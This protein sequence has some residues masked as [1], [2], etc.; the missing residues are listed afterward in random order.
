MKYETLECTKKDGTLTVML[1]RPEV[2]NA[3]NESLMRELTTCFKDASL[4]STVAAVVLTGNGKSFCAGADLTWM[5]QMV[6]YSKEENRNDSRLLL[7]MYET[8]HACPK[9]VIGRVNGS[10]FGGGIGLV[11]ICDITIT[12]PESLFGFT[13]V[14]LGIIPAVISTFVAHRM[15]LAS[16]RR[17]FITGERFT[18]AVA[19]EVGLIDLVV[20]AERLDASVD[21]SLEQIYSS[22]PG[23]IKEVKHLL[24]KHL[25]LDHH[26]YKEYTVEKIAELRVS[27]EGQEG[28]SA[29]LEKR[30]PR[31]K[32]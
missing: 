5:K 16:M 28:I 30:K 13:E 22:G 24:Y 25:E 12:P 21:A 3:M 29:F 32:R 23:A 31:W 26:D 8:L 20:P 19:H 14:K 15:S 4:D 7:E 2:H 11:A 10:A 27:P 9:P 1:N 6:Q 18:A 17:L